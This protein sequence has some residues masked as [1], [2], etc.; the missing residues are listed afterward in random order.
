MEREKDK[1]SHVA[2]SDYKRQRKK[3]RERERDA[4]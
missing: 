2:A 4:G 1:F 3:E